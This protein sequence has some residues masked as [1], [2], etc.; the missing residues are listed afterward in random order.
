MSYDPSLTT[1]KDL[2]RL[3]ADDTD[4]AEEKFLD[5]TIVSLL[6]LAKGNRVTR[7]M[8]VAA[9]LLDAL[10]GRYASAGGGIT[11]KKFTD[12]EVEI[13]GGGSGGISLL[14]G[15]IDQLRRQAVLAEDSP[16]FIQATG[17]L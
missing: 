17:V 16:T 3:Y 11:R 2:V 8:L 4:V 1:D 9:D 10:L 14:R 12:S 15:R 6:A 5:E 13:G 7:S